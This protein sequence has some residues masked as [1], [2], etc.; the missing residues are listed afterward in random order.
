MIL[1]A[2]AQHYET[3]RKK[4]K[5]PQYGFSIEK[6]AA[7]ITIA[8]NGELIQITPLMRE[9]QSGKKLKTISQDRVVPTPSSA[10][11][12]DT[13]NF[14][15]DA[16]DYL[17]GIL[18][19]AKAPRTVKR[20]EASAQL[21]HDVLSGCSGPVATAIL[22]FYRTWIPSV[23][24]CTIKDNL[25]LIVTGSMIFEVK[26]Y[27]FAHEDIEVQ[28][29]WLS[30]LNANASEIKMICLVSGKNSPIA[31]V[32]RKIK[33]IAGGHPAGTALV[34][35]NTESVESY[36]HVQGLN[37]PV[38]EYAANA[39]VTALNYLL[40]NNKNTTRIGDATVVY[41]SE[42][43]DEAAQEMLRI[44]LMMTNRKEDEDKLRNIMHRITCA[45]PLDEIDLQCPCHIVGFS[46]NGGRI[47]VRFY[48]RNSL[49]VFLNN[50]NAHYQ[51]LE[52][53]HARNERDYLSPWELLQETVN[54]FGRDKQA[55]PLLAGAFLRSILQNTRYPAALYQATLLR[56]HAVQDNLEKNIKK[57]SRG[58][59]A[60]L[61]AC[62]LMENALTNDQKEA[63][64]PMLNEDST[65][66]AYVLGRLFAVL[67]N[68]QQTASPNL[69]TT[70]KNRYFSSAC[71]TPRT[72]FPRLLQLNQH[73]MNKISNEGAK[74]NIS[75]RIGTL[76]D[77]LDVE[78]K[79]FP[80]YLSLQDQGLF[81]LGYYQQTQSHYRGN[82]EEA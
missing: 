27:G 39:Y 59:A 54:P 23:Q 24:H 2:L 17:F 43:D 15:Y 56:L 14:L 40:S 62:L 49:G 3:L 45:L 71:M 46:P 47:S 37:A 7:L 57:V 20:H 32:H 35:F 67:E 12:G 16:S 64:T 73:H 79:P 76:M 75:K 66:K 33:G 61:K 82:K 8:P 60:I 19:G 50:I 48:L 51:R 4:D 41:W 9:V 44:G 11:S 26:G 78:N 21:H 29:A 81:V 72:V 22:A 28:Q 25:D 38:S 58:R 18:P 80:A 1:Q 42:N 63:L 65:N 13:P 55:S 77:K 74:V 30:F 5:V 68:A 52:I 36:K 6:T 70:I 69:T 10:T 34:S 31:L 53:T